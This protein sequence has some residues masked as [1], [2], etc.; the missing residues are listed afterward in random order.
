MKK[1]K[2]FEFS[3]DRPLTPARRK[4]IEKH[5][6]QNADQ[7]EKPV[8][9]SW[10][11]D[12]GDVLRIEADPVEIEVRFEATKVELFGAAPLWARLLFTAKKKAELKE[13]IEA[14]L[15]KA[16]FVTASKAG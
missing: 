4:A 9:Y 1:E 5:I 8:S 15:Q 13:Q 14:L 11:D 6:E 16:K 12:D 2:I 3:I 7:S 10:D